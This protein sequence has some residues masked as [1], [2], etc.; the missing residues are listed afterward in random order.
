MENPFKFGGIVRGPHFAD[1]RKEM[2]ELVGEMKNLGRIFLVSP[3][4]YGKTCLLFNL[5]DRLTELGFATVYI[6]L[7]AY[8][9]IKSV[10]GAIT[11][12]TC[13]AM[14]SNADKLMKIFAGLQR[15][16]PK[17]SVGR[18]GTIEVGL[19]V[20]VE[21]K[22]ALPALLEGMSH[23]NKLASR[24]RKKTVIIIDEFSDITK[25]NGQTL[26]KALRSEIQKHEYI[27]Y[28]FSGSEQSVMLSMI[29]D[30]KRAF[31]KLGRVMELG[32]IERKTYTDFITKWLKKGG[33]RIQPNDLQKVFEI[34]M[35]VPHNIQR[36]CNIMWELA[37]KNRNVTHGLIAKLPEVIAGQDS[38]H[39]EML[40]HTVSQLQKV[41]L[42]SLSQ[43][44]AA[45]PFSREFQMKYGIGPSSS[46]KASLDSLTKKGILFKSIAGTYQFSDSFMPYWINLIRHGI[47]R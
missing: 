33:Y 27:G 23:A 44:P 45:K 26:E 47:Y 36:L 3:R 34:G 43:E 37:R 20:S 46:V 25:Y 8:P 5:I 31:Y 17:A 29:R 13:R 14:E 12:L 21:E 24:K 9:D 40:W 38:P 16:R 39:Y 7:N 41:L 10:A 18:D 35:D 32:L 30:R 28:I 15:L 42:I 22:E 6:D 11:N 19:E 1:R 2:D 4:R